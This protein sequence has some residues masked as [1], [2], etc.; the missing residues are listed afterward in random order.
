MSRQSYGNLKRE[1]S[2]NLHMLSAFCSWFCEKPLSSDYWVWFSPALLCVLH[3]SWPFCLCWWCPSCFCFKIKS[4]EK[5]CF[6]SNSRNTRLLN[7][8]KRNNYASARWYHFRLFL[9]CSSLGAPEAWW[10]I[11]GHFSGTLKRYPHRWRHFPSKQ[12]SVVNKFHTWKGK[13]KSLHS[14]TSAF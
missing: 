9:C 12:D 8:R 10:F 1:V 14:L 5:K 7:S 2:L 6:S 3:G 13:I 11:Q 4:N